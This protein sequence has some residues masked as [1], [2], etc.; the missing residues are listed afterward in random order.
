MRAPGGIKQCKA[1]IKLVI[2]GEIKVVNFG[3]TVN[4]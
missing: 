4:L 1:H 2:F 3:T